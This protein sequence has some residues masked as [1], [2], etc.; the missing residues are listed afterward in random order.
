[1][2]S[3]K[4]KHTIKNSNQNVY[5]YFLTFYSAYFNLIREEYAYKYRFYY[6]LIRE[7]NANFQMH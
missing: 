2:L 7:N 4:K 5:L 1:M 3:V 6:A